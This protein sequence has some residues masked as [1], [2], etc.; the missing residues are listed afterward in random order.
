MDRIQLF[1]NAGKKGPGKVQ[2]IRALFDSFEKKDMSFEDFLA[3]FTGATSP[4][5]L[6]EDL[7]MVQME[8][9][10]RTEID[11]ALKANLN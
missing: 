11:N 3:E 6:R 5:K 2:R 9:H 4:K 10:K 1:G 8:K 7:Q